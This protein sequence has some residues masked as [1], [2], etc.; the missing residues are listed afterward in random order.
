M[1]SFAAAAACG[2][3]IGYP[4]PVSKCT[5]FDRGKWASS[6]LSQSEVTQPF[7]PNIVTFYEYST[8]YGMNVFANDPSKLSFVP[9]V[10]I[11]FFNNK[12]NPIKPDVQ[13]KDRIWGFS[14]NVAQVLGLYSAATDTGVGS[15]ADYARARVTLATY[16]GGAVD[17]ARAE[18]VLTYKFHSPSFIVG[19]DVG[20]TTEAVTVGADATAE[21]RPVTYEWW[22][23]GVHQGAAGDLASIN[24][25]F[26][27]PGSHAVRVVVRANDGHVYDLTKY[28]Q[29]TPCPNGEIIC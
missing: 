15:G 4:D 6:G 26:S 17:S 22:V 10:V 28:I 20:S 12:G 24:H 3:D 14:G 18:A 11:S 21:Y 23:D 25:L 7:C 16:S 8:Q 19:P 13:H 29:I 2:V 27:E 1:L 9:V 5:V